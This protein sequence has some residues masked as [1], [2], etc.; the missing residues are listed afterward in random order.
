MTDLPV[1]PLDAMRLAR[2]A[3]DQA[4]TTQAAISQ[5]T[6]RE[7]L[8]YGESLTRILSDLESLTVVLAGQVARHGDSRVSGHDAERTANLQRTV[9]HLTEL[10]EVLHTA[11]LHA[12][13]Y[14][15]QLRAD[16]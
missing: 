11:A 10:A 7:F 9:R 16:S 15:S 1:D 4:S 13:G 5:P 12:N 8:A 3:L 6:S 2:R 14:W